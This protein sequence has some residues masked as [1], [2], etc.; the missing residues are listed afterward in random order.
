MVEQAIAIVTFASPPNPPPGRI[1]PVLFLM[2]YWVKTMRKFTAQPGQA[3]TSLPGLAAY[4][5]PPKS[6][7][8]KVLAPE[9]TPMNST[10]QTAQEKRPANL[11]ALRQMLQ[12]MAASVKSSPATTEERSVV[13]QGPVLVVRGK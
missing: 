8:D 2:I 13:V 1:L 10:S 6:H 11:T 3:R 5:K 12:E 9:D 4:R 7:A